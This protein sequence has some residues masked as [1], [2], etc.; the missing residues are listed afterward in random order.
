MKYMNDETHRTWNEI[1]MNDEYIY[2]IIIVITGTVAFP[3]EKCFL[4]FEHNGNE[5]NKI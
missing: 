3:N 2:I 5:N 4:A 1:Y